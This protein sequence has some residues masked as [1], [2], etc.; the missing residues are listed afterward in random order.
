MATVPNIVLMKW[1]V[2]DVVAELDSYL[3]KTARD[4]KVS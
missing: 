3:K 4:V 2:T 1:E